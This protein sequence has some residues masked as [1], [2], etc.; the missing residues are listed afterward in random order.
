MRIP[1]LIVAWAVA[2]ASCVTTGHSLPSPSSVPKVKPGGD[3]LVLHDEVKITFAL[4]RGEPV[5]IERRRRVVLIEGRRSKR[6]ADLS[7]AYDRTFSS[8][9]HVSVAARSP[10][11]E[12]KTWGRGDARDVPQFGGSILY[13]DTRTLT[14]DI[15]DP[16]EGTVVEHVSE[17]RRRSAPLFPYVHV[18]ED[19]VPTKV[20]SIAME[21]P[22]GWEIDWL[23]EKRAAPV[24]LKPTVVESADKK[25]YT[26]ERK[27]LGALK[28][29]DLSP[30]F[31]EVAERISIRLASWRGQ[32]GQVVKAPANDKEDSRYQHQLT[33]KS[34][35]RSPALEAEV[36]KVLEGVADDPRAKARRLYAWVRDRVRYCAVEVGLGGWIPHDAPKVFEGRAGDCKDKA[37]LLRTMLDV[38]GISSHLVPIF[39]DEWPRRY[40]LPVLAANFNHAILAIDLP[41]GR[42]FVDP[43]SRT[44][45]F[46]D[47]P[48]G[49]EDRLALLTDDAGSGLVAMSESS[50]QS[51]VLEDSYELV[52]H[53]DGTA[54][55]SFVSTL[56]GA[57]ADDIRRRL[58]HEPKK[59]HVDV[60]EDAIALWTP[61]VRDAGLV[62]DNAQPPEEPVPVRVRGELAT[63]V[64]PGLVSGDDLVLRTRVFVAGG[65]QLLDSDTRDMP[66]LLGHRWRTSSVIRLRLPPTLRAVAVPDDARHDSRWGTYERRVRAEDD[67]A[68]LVFERTVTRLQRVVPSTEAT[69]Y[70][71]FAQAVSQGDDAP[72]VLE[73]RRP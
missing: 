58:L 35:V 5:A 61:R 64:A 36:R 16:G 31:A 65:A 4:E 55:G 69:S 15:P 67:G 23:A 71:A 56:G 10:S 42:V 72:I 25:V 11:G 29:P 49:D 7:I 44:A 1:L 38:A 37:N 57:F 51:D 33:S 48:S 52:L 53:A 39:S 22:L 50:V 73:G 28:L 21:V 19:A 20:A 14:I 41:G 54:K 17:I 59:R 18:F 26:W 6:L 9:E 32:D 2:S 45:A 24:E 62:I 68:V 8:V 30:P 47:L 34:R 13:S 3:G 43:T 12:Q 40:R 70:S 60:V 63:D 66:I 27:N 46:G